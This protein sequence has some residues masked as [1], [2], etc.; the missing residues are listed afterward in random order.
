[1][2]RITLISVSTLAL[3]LLGLYIGLTIHGAN[4]RALLACISGAAG[5]FGIGVIGFDVWRQHQ[6]L[7]RP[8]EE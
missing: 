4:L 8:V 3:A 6:A 5:G 7:K 2:W 1:M